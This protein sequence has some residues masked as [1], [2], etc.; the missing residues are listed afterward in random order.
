MRPLDLDFF[1][2]GTAIANSAF[3]NSGLTKKSRY[4]NARK[5]IY[6]CAVLLVPHWFSSVLSASSAAQ[7][8]SRTSREHEHGADCKSAPH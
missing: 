7:R 6:I 2:F 5:T 3:V 1:F 4:Y 8:S